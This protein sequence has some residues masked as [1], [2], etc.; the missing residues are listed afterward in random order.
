MNVQYYLHVVERGFGGIY[1]QVGMGDMYASA[2]VYGNFALEQHI[3]YFAEILESDMVSV[4]ARLLDLSPKR[5]YMMGFLVNDSRQQLAASVEVI[6]MNVDTKQRRGAPFPS[7]V[8]SE[9]ERLLSEHERL[10][11]RAPACGVMRA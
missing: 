6:A 4:Y 8:F 3:R 2:D 11:W 9:L 5:T 1:R 10:P 7:A